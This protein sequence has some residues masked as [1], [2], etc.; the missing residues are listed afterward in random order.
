MKP[1]QNNET[2]AE[3]IQRDPM[4][5]VGLDAGVASVV[6][7][8]QAE[9]QGA[10][11]LAKRYPRNPNDCYAKIVSACQTPEIAEKGVYSFPRGKENIQGLSVYAAREMIKLWG[12][13]RCGVRLT[14]VEDNYVHIRG[15]CYDLESNHW[16]E[17]EDKF[18]KL[19]QR[20]DKQTKITHWVAA[21]E[22]ELREL[23]NK[24]GAMAMRNAIL[25]VLP[26]HITSHAKALILK[27]QVEIAE[28]TLAKSRAQSTRELVIAFRALGVSGE[29]LETKIG[30]KLDLLTGE[31]FAQL[32]GILQSLAD[33][34][35]RREDH[36]DMLA[37]REATSDLEEKLRKAAKEKGND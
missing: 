21:D 19:I 15:Y 10:I 26:T 11:I 3:L 13:T 28:K 22:R 1:M 12:N 5:V 18:S 6:A 4:E 27:T 29:M 34:Y 23:V 35:T 25:Q 31:E 24:R 36:F 2:G 37:R 30:N 33:G 20:K 32:K 7:R 14:S 16:V 8:E 17:G 9:L